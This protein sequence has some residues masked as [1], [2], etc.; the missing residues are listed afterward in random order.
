MTAKK[1]IIKYGLGYSLYGIKDEVDLN[2]KTYMEKTS[3]CT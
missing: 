1:E 2:R 3:K